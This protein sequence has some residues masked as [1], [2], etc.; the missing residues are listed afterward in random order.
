MKAPNIHF[1]AS[2]HEKA[3]DA[4]IEMIKKYGQVDPWDCDVVV[5]LG[6]DGTILNV[7][8]AGY[9]KPVYGLN[10]GSLGFLMN[11]FERKLVLSARINLA[12]PTILHP[13]RAEVETV[14]GVKYVLAAINDVSLHRQSSQSAKIDIYVNGN[15]RLP[16]G[17]G[18][19]VVVSTPAGST[20]Y[21]YSLGGSI[22]PLDCGSINVVPNAFFRPRGWRGAVLSNRTQ[23]C[24]DVKEH[25]KRPVTLTADSDDLPDVKYVKV[26]VDMTTE[27]VVLFD[28]DRDLSDRIIDEQFSF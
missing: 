2:L 5:A 25:E 10:R 12:E 27:H 16:E 28:N 24:F 3:Q 26:S 9:G 19:G 8:K 6:G 18:D 13:L 22:L 21:N 4:L 23:L 7:L 15:L 1:V 20:A 14:A 11:D 17:C